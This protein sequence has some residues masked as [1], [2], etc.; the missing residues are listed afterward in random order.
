MIQNLDQMPKGVCSQL[1]I[2]GQNPY[3][4]KVATRGQGIPALIYPWGDSN[5]SFTPGQEAS[6]GGLLLLYGPGELRAPAGA[7]FNQKIASTKLLP[8]PLLICWIPVTSSCRTLWAAL[9]MGPRSLKVRG[10]RK[11]EGW[12]AREKANPCTALRECPGAGT[13]ATRRIS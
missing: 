3:L 10:R 4:P 5:P 6:L 8:F 1:R 2:Q 9:K 13:P 7:S 12:W 11:L